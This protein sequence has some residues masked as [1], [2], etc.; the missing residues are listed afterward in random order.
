M[1]YGMA[2]KTEVRLGFLRHV[3]MHRLGTI[4]SATSGPLSAAYHT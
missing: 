1:L 3:T 2:D 4:T